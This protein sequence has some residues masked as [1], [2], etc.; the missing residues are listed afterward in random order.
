MNGKR[1]SAASTPANHKQGAAGGD[2]GRMVIAHRESAKALPGD[3]LR[4][5]A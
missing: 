2:R 5:A 1:E 4:R 3:A